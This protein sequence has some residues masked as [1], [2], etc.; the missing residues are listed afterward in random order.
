MYRDHW[1]HDWSS[2]QWIL[3][4]AV[5]VAFWAVLIVLIGSL[6]PGRETPAQVPLRRATDLPA[7]SPP[8]RPAAEDIL[9]ERFARGEIDAEEFR[10]RSEVLH[11]HRRGPSGPSPMLE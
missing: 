11:T 2:W 6:C 9:A 1:H 5:G 3:M 10:H 7:A 4:I 8:H